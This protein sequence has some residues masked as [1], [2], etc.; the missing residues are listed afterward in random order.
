MPE[1]V[2]DRIHARHQR[3]FDDLQ[4]TGELLPRFLGV[5]FDKIS[6][7]P[8][9]RVTEAFFD[10]RLA[11]GLVSFYL[12]AAA[13]DRF[14]ERD[15]ALGGVGAAVEQHVLDALEQVL[16]NLLVNFQHPGVD[17]AHVEPGANRV[18][19]KRRVHR[20]A[21]A[22]VAAKR[23][24]NVAHPARHER[25]GEVFLNPLRRADKVHGVVRV[26]LEP[27]RHRENVR[28]EDDVLRFETHLVNQNPVSALANFNA[29]LEA[30]G[31]TAFVEGHHHGGGPV[32][33][34]EP[35]L[36]LENL[37]AFFEADGIHHA[38]ALHALQTGLEHRKLRRVDHDR[39]TGDVRLAGDEV[40]KRDHRRLAVQHPLVHVDVD[41]L[42]ATLD[43][44]ARDAQSF[45]VLVV[46]D[47]A[48][49]PARAGDVRALADVDEV[50][51]WPHDEGLEAR[52][53]RVS[54]DFGRHARR[55][56]GG[57][58][59]EQGNVLGRGAAAAAQDVDPTVLEPLFHHRRHALR[60]FVVAAE[61]VR[62]PGVRVGVGEVFGHSGQ[63]LDVLAEF[64]RPER[65]VQPHSEHVGVRDAD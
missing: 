41:N 19:Q 38:L 11:P 54:R 36:L 56:L 50:G 23:E 34:D 17:D 55:V 31:L 45:V 5:H 58:F 63:F 39:H 51:V 14:G 46:Q 21:H 37:F 2:A 20:L 15:E 24:R 33:P 65:A 3:A 16:G 25:A 13:R 49:E 27:R 48:G 62:Q 53:P 12:F 7:A 8:D 44:T 40:Q 42:R 61:S 64:L 60:R 28:V 9:E 52:K 10:T 22:V 6:D 43:L 32:A 1:Q 59:S 26:F 47:E 35:R 4:R 29:A 57:G 18:V 30:V